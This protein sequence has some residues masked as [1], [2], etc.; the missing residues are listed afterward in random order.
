MWIGAQSKKAHSM[1][2]KNQIGKY[3]MDDISGNNSELLWEEQ[4][5]TVIPGNST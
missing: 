2:G 4:G 3:D 1:E 5:A